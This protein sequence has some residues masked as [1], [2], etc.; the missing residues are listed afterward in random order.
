MLAA[1]ICGLATPLKSSH[2]LW[3]NLI[4]DSMPAL[5]LGIDEEENRSYMD[6][7][8]RPKEESLFAGGGW[9]CTGF[10]GCLIAAISIAAFLQI[11]VGSLLAEGSP[12]TL[13]N[14]RL[15][16]TQPDI[17]SRSQTY[18]FTVLGMAQL[19][20]AVGM[21]DVERSV[22]RM[23]HLENRLMLLAVAVG[24]GLQ[25]LVTEVP[26]FIGL[27]GTSRLSAFEWAGLLLLAAVP[28][29]AHEILI[30]L[31]YFEKRE[32]PPKEPAILWRESG[33]WH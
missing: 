25:V 29:A 2:I 8:P 22:F 4:T 28:L 18:A 11:P 3:I 23:N 5:A 9:S 13:Q 21:R 16:L 6:R 14:L 31:A 10:Y 7:P 26:Y 19:F 30:L 27:F 20:H 1:V 24:I 32:K 17:L 15:L 12:L 33:K